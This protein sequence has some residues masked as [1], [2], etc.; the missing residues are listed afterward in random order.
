MSGLRV[1]LGI[2][3]SLASVEMEEMNVVSK[4]EGR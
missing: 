2:V 3:K 1:D 4:H